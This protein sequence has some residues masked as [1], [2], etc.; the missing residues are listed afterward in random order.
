VSFVDAQVG[1]VLAALDRL[2]LR[3]NT[4]VV[5]WGDHGY[6]L[7][8]KGK[9]SKANSLFEAGTRVPL[10]IS[11][12]RFAGNGHRCDRIV[13]SV[14]IYPTLAAICGLPAPPGIKGVSL[15]P[16]LGNPKAE[17]NRPAYSFARVSSSGVFG[18]A[19]RTDRWRYV[20]W[21]AGEQGAMLFDH[22]DDPNEFKNIAT[23][24]AHANIVAGMKALLARFPG[25]VQ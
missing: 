21:N 10:L 18:R 2:G 13:Q 12:P 23:D 22:R 6:H 1:R 14:D 8:E 25:R 3:D 4:V 17:W 24:P 7:G 11:A 20:E 5:F 19:V 16:L 15:T 9:W